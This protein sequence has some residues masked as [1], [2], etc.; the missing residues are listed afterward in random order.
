MKRLLVLFFISI[1][2]ATFSQ[3]ITVTERTQLAIP[4]KTECF[5]PQFSPDGNSVY[6]TT[7]S[8]KGIFSYNLKSKQI[9]VLNEDLG[10]GYQFAISDDGN[11]IYY[12]KD[13]FIKRKKYSSMIA[14][15]TFDLTRKVLAEPQR[16]LSTPQILN[17]GDV[18]YTAQY[19][20]TFLEAKTNKQ[21]SLKNINQTFASIE[22]CKIALYKNG[23]KI[24]LEP[25]GEG[26][27]IWPS[28][29]PDGKHLLFTLAGK[30]TYISDLN[31]NII[32]DLGYAD[33]PVW[34]PDGN[35]VV[36]MVDRDNGIEV[37]SSD[38]FVSS[39]DGSKKYQLTKT[40]NV[41]EMYPV[42]NNAGNEIL[43]NT[44][45]GNLFILTLKIE[46]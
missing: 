43:C 11:T 14:Q 2:T 12:R 1:V 38:I 32:S 10:A 5:F 44:S 3:N 9:R 36:Y 46:E 33:S 8:Y 29:S 24:I 21:K 35:W 28:I 34:S 39:V 40:E 23:S 15:S 42:W 4:G 18:L 13:E 7:S 41:H 20:M 37:T 45:Q 17:S 19:R 30:G 27:Y 25:A 6:Y 16:E 22:N 31:G 26:N